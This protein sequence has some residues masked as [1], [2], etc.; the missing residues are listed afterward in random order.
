MSNGN[1]KE[2]WTGTDDLLLSAADASSETSAKFNGDVLTQIAKAGG[3]SN[4]TSMI[5]AANQNLTADQFLHNPNDGSELNNGAKFLF[6]GYYWIPVYL[7][8]DKNGNAILDLWLADAE[9][10]AQWNTW[11]KNDAA[12]NYPSNMYSSSYVRSYLMGTDYIANEEDTELTSGTQSEVWNKFLTDLGWSYGQSCSFLVSPSEVTYQETESIVDYAAGQNTNRSGVSYLCAN[13]AYGTPKSGSFLKET[14]DYGGANAKA[15]YSDWQN[16][17]LW[18]P[19]LTETGYRGSQGMWKLTQAEQAS[20]DDTWLRSANYE[21]AD[22]AY[23]LSCFG[24]YCYSYSVTKA[25]GVRPAIHLNLNSVVSEAVFE[26]DAPE[27]TTV[28][29]TGEKIDFAS[30][31]ETPTWF[32]SDMMDVEISENCVDVGEYD[33][34]ATIKSDSLYTFKTGNKSETFKLVVE[35]KKLSVEWVNDEDGVPHAELDSTQI[36]ERD[37]NYVAI[38]TTYS[39]ASTLV[40]CDIP[41]KAGS[42]I[43]TATLVS[44]DGKSDNYKN[45]QLQ[46]AQREFDYV[47]TVTADSVTWQYVNNGKVAKFAE[48]NT[49]TYNGNSYK[50]QIDENRIPE[51]IKVKE[52]GGTTSA[53]NANADGEYTTTVVLT[54]FDDTYDYADTTFTLHWNIAPQSIDLTWTTKSQTDTNGFL[55]DLPVVSENG[56]MVEYVYYRLNKNGEVQEKIDLSDIGV[57]VEKMYY[58]VKATL[59]SEYAQN[60]RLV[61]ETRWFSIDAGQTL[62]GSIDVVIDGKTDSSTDAATNSTKT[63]DGNSNSGV[64]M[65]ENVAEKCAIVFLV[66]CAL[67]AVIVI[68]SVIKK[69]RG[70][71]K[72]K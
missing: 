45:Y 18:L 60:Y 33:V 25:H 59:K 46:S 32:K 3:F 4:V 31:S 19:S 48:G 67:L 35:P 39:D 65:P 6:G 10:S 56:D 9:E 49:V 36:A 51:G 55:F 29:Y 40:E 16:D 69:L 15:G 5:A 1:Y 41:E 43:A 8:T 58:L 26:T 21:S 13:D 50:I 42:Y 44:L 30:L 52:Y 2:D 7:T 34:V 37:A 14:Y 64:T 53:T 70:R 54:A 11:S 63:T 57:N 20:T 24:G 38:E 12:S 22:Y 71:R 61:G 66:V 72:G 62:S 68:I 17:Y 28:T 23:T 47:Q 27:T